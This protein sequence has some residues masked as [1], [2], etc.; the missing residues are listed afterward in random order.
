V[1]WR[2]KVAP[3][4]WSRWFVFSDD[5]AA[6]AFVWRLRDSCRCFHG[7]LRRQWLEMKVEDGCCYRLK[8]R[9]CAGRLV[10]ARVSVAVL[11]RV[12]VVQ[13]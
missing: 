8:A 1:Q 6:V 5:L 3:R 13:V 9:T 12:G 7:G 2:N 10:V 11:A 4:C